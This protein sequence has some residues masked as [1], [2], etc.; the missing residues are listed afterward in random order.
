MELLMWRLECAN[1]E[2]TDR[3]LAAAGTLFLCHAPTCRASPYQSAGKVQ[4]GG[5]KTPCPSGLAGHLQ[6]PMRSLAEGDQC[7]CHMT[8]AA[9]TERQSTAAA[10]AVDHM[11]REEAY[12]VMTAAHPIRTIIRD[13]L[14]EYWR[15]KRERLGKPLVRRLQAPTS[16]SDQ[17]PFAVFRCALSS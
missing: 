3:A 12:A 13:A 2:A 6:S 10:A 8:G 11:T 15:A 4:D 14:Y 16:S 7:T 1:A 17:N 9:Q 5:V